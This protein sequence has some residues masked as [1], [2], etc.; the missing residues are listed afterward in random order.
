PGAGEGEDG[1]IGRNE[2]RPYERSAVS[3]G[4]QFIAPFR[5]TRAQQF[6]WVHVV[7]P[8][9][10]LILGVVLVWLPWMA[11]N[12]T[13]HDSFSADGN[14]GSTLVGRAMRHDPGFAFENPSD[15][16]PDRQRAREIM[17]AG[18]G[19]VVTPTR[20]RIK[21]ELGL[22]DDQA[23]KL[24]RDLALETILRQPGYYL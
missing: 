17:R 20:T 15:P 2:L 16:D 23:N 8:G 12:A 7:T 13:V 11:R 22:T 4:A 18:R 3:V 10:S 5:D 14:A 19:K 21:R 1:D 9:L 6:I 24:M